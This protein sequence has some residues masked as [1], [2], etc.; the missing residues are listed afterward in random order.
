QVL[1]NARKI[2]TVAEMDRAVTAFIDGLHLFEQALRDFMNVERVMKPGGL[3][4]IDDIFPAHPA[5]A[6]RVRR[7]KKWAGD[8]WKVLKILQEHRPDL[9]L[10]ALD[11]APTGLLLVRNLDP[12]S[13]ILEEAYH[14]LVDEWMD[15][16]VPE[17]IIRRH[18]CTQV[19]IS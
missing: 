8:V 16:V 9:E 12:G 4:V 10:T 17:D 5:Q 1:F 18:A 14:D 7:T 11:V 15:Q 3:V 6:E 2:A 19:R 13:R